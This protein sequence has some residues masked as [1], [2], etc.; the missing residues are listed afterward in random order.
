[1]KLTFCGA[2]RTVTGSQHLIEVNGKRILLD[3]GLYQ[4][5]R[6]DTYTR[7]QTFLYDPATV[8]VLVLSH[9][10]IDHSGNI[11]NLARRGFRGDIIC[12]SATRDLASTM[13]L[14]SAH[15][16]E[17]DIEFLNKKRAKKG[18]PPVPP[19]YTQD[20][21]RACLGLFSSQEIGRP[22]II[23]NGV[24]CTLYDAGHM[25]GSN[26][27][28]LDIEDRDAG[29]D[30]RLV[31]SGDL[32]RKG[33]P[34]LRDPATIDRADVLILESTYGDR[35]HPPLEDDVRAMERIIADTYKRG[36]NV[37]IPAFAVGRTQQVVYALHQLVARGDLPNVPI[38]VDSP[39]A[40]DVTSIFR[41]HSECYD[42]ETLKFLNESGARDPFGFERLIYTRTTEESKQLNFL[43]TP[44]VIISASGMAEA[45][46][47]LHHLKNNI[48]NPKNTVLIV[49]YQA[50]NTLGR[51]IA[52][53]EKTVRIFGENYDNRAQVAVLQGFSGHG[54]RDDLLEWVGAMDQKPSHT[55]LVHGEDQALYALQGALQ[56]QFQLDVTVP[57][58][59]QEVS[60]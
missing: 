41:L 36:G 52:D 33:L 14:D 21:V 35:L 48:E 54:D 29:K 37:I 40:I 34:I 31:F 46:R 25:M 6:A 49:G 12:T 30:V 51:R 5:H 18:E 22:R 45:G 32:G 3:C 26:F 42:D 53:G 9:A 19:L 39:L 10:H 57:D 8:D 58:W 43:T 23:A 60:I 20:D 11:P 47:V 15:I 13:L 44:A 17:D 24:T 56:Q 28:V 7:N 38:Y 2:A 50:E 55:F 1:M 59:K 16:Q 27:V 4:G